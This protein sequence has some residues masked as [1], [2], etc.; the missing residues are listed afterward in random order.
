MNWEQIARIAVV[1]LPFLTAMLGVV[2][3]QDAVRRRIGM[4]SAALQRLPS[5]SDAHRI[6]LE[7]LA[8]DAA[9]L[10]SRMNY[11]R[12]PV[13]LA[14]SIAGS[15]LLGYLTIW[16]WS[17]ATWWGWG[18]A[19]VSGLLWLVFFFGIFDSAQLRD[20]HAHTLEKEAEK[21]AKAAAKAAKT[22]S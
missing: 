14:L 6:L 22:P 17:Q 21:K 18:G 7:V 16:L 19:V 5:E 20:Q 15:L 12:E 9:V 13:G 1:V 8:R 10:N 2:A 3:H 11:S 4:D